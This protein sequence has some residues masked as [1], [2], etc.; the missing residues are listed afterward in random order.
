MLLIVKLNF[1]HFLEIGKIKQL[2]KKIDVYRDYIT[3]SDK[4]KISNYI[5][6]TFHYNTSDSFV[7]FNS[8]F[9]TILQINVD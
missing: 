9:G 7:I 2:N 1:L 4:G 5:A 8:K 6:I 3:K